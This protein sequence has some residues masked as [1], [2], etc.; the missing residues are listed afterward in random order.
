MIH[1]MSFLT[2]R[3]MA[4]LGSCGIVQSNALSQPREIA[5]F[6]IKVTSIG[7]YLNGRYFYI[8]RSM[9]WRLNWIALKSDSSKTWVFFFFFGGGG[10]S[11]TEK[12]AATDLNWD[13]FTCNA[14]DI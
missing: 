1:I 14:V 13:N 4:S 12:S 9:W 11:P 8:L 6:N 3:L 7:T 10:C 2:S 5:S